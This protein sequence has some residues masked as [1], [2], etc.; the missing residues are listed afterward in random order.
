VFKY[1][2]SV[3]LSRTLAPTCSLGPVHGVSGKWGI[4]VPLLRRVGC[5]SF[6]FVHKK[7]YKYHELTCSLVEV[8][9]VNLEEL[10]MKL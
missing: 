10:V 5:I 8:N 1:G 2:G 7:I 3:E 9:L 4:I 6:S